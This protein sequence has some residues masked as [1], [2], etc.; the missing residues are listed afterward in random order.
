MNLHP[1]ACS[2]CRANKRKCS[3]EL[4]AC[5]RCRRLGFDCG[6]LPAR[7]KQPVDHSWHSGRTVS[8]VKNGQLSTEFNGLVLLDFYFVLFIPSS[9]IFHQPC[10]KR[11]YVEGH[12]SPS[13][14]DS[15]FSIALLLLEARTA[16]THHLVDETSTPQ[17]TKWPARLWAERANMAAKQATRPT[18]DAVQ[19]YYNLAA[20]WCAVGGTSNFRECASNAMQSAQQV[21]VGNPR[22]PPDEARELKQSCFWIAMTC[23]S[24]LKND[25]FVA[26]FDSVLEDQLSLRE[27]ILPQSPEIVL[28]SFVRGRIMKLME[29]WLKIR[30]FVYGLYDDAH[31][32]TQLA[33]LINLDTE[34]CSIY[35]TFPP[36]YLNFDGR[37][38]VGQSEFDDVISLQTIYHLC[39]ILPHLAM[40]RFLQKQE[41]WAQAHILP[42]SKIAARHINQISDILTTCLS[43]QQCF[44]S[45]LPPFVAYCSLVS[46]S[47]YF[48]YVE[49]IQNRSTDS[50]SDRNP[51]F[52]LLRVRLLS[53]LRLLKQLRG[54]WAPVNAMWDVLQAD[55]KSARIS[56]RDVDEFLGEP[57][58]PFE[59]TTLAPT[60]PMPVCPKRQVEY[61]MVTNLPQVMRS[62]VLFDPAYILAGILQSFPLGAKPKEQAISPPDAID[63]SS[64]EA[65][66]SP[67][68]SLERDILSMPGHAWKLPLDSNAQSPQQIGEASTQFDHPLQSESIQTESS[69]NFMPNVSREAPLPN[70]DDPTTF[71][72]MM[73]MMWL[74]GNELLV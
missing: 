54:F 26:P 20:Y 4:P 18:L 68:G 60:P 49:S 6:Y 51:A 58:A 70:L 42:C 15:I 32:G 28:G 16:P 36:E 5:H 53:N 47:V 3:R 64:P 13:V 27:E 24:L 48:K 17:G 35:R 39:R 55:M 45:A 37:R 65:R 72:G 52:R 12:I 66:S 8:V 59:R 69:H 43:V 50:A 9:F 33:T 74:D 14:R 23:R 25:F 34:A 10:V 38:W 21:A 62:T 41:P 61:F 2:R 1:I 29:L 7:R 71:K 46:S 19:T 63:S 56:D 40:A 11:R 44:R 67:S 73:E 22:L 30:Q 57:C 31:P